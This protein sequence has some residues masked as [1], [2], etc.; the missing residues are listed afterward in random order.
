M[1]MRISIDGSMSIRISIS[2]RVCTRKRWLLSYQ[3][4]RDYVLSRGWPVASVGLTAL[5]S[6]QP[7]EAASLAA[8]PFTMWLLAHVRHKFLGGQRRHAGLVRSLR[9]ASALTVDFSPISSAQLRLVG[10]LDP[11]GLAHS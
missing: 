10:G 6:S 9:S 3:S 11:T 2:I 5:A 4:R 8:T 1:R 7:Y